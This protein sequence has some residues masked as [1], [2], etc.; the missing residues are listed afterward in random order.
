MKTLA[1]SSTENIVLPKMGIMTQ[2]IELSRHDYIYVKNHLNENTPLIIEL[3][4]SRYWDENALAVFYKGFKLGYL[5][6]TIS[7]VV[8]KLMT[9]YGGVSAILKHKT[10]AKMPF[11][12]IDILIKIG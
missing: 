1:L 4:K 6:Q 12:G 9:K 5:N 7:K 2:L 8:K 10:T 11:D 3:D